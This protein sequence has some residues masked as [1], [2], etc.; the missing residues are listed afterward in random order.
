MRA[1]QADELASGATD[2]FVAGGT[3]AHFCKNAGLWGV[4]LWGRPN[5]EDIG[6]LV[7]TLHFELRPPAVP[8]VS[9]VDASRLAGV[10]PR[11]F[12]VLDRYVREQFEALARAVQRLALVRPTGVE[13]AVVAGFFEVLPRPYTVSVFDDLRAALG[14]LGAPESFAVDMDALH[15]R[16]AQTP[17]L[18]GK[19]RAYLAAHLADAN[20]TSA[21]RALTL[22]ER[23]LQRRL[24]EAGTT[25]QQELVE[26]RVRA[27]QHLLLDSDA[28]LTNIALDVGCASLQHFSALF[29]KATGESPSAWRARHRS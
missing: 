1:C 4:I 13:G 16:A 15:A 11:A 27:A 25:F 22:S 5:E 20:V 19:L 9:V 3:F 14:W 29:R 10:D 28:P 26:A 7:R 8:H 12:A 21:A 18:L 23:T 2:C 17:P 6:A 24:G